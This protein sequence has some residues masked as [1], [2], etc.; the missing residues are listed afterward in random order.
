MT[1]DRTD[2]TEAHALDEGLVAGDA[3]KL[4]ERRE[5][6]R[7]RTVYRAIRLNVRGGASLGHLCNISDDGMMISTDEAIAANEAITVELSPGH[8]LT[9]RAIWVKDG[10]C[11]IALDAPVESETLL[12]EL[13]LEQ[14]S[15]RHRAPRIEAR[16]LGVAYSER[17]M[18]PIRMLNLSQQ[19]MGL[20]HDG[21]L[22]PGLRLLVTLENGLERRGV[23]RWSREHSAGILLTEPLARA[24]VNRCASMV[25]GGN[26]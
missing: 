17:G 2:F 3:P 16:L 9:G 4:G 14:R 8:Q 26:C 23:V 20:T 6:C 12:H 10:H 22:E 19:G 1:T 24:D 18:H 21:R 25:A 5:A 13:A 15:S 11:G 7:H